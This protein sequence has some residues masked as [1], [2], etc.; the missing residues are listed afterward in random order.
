MFMLRFAAGLSVCA[1][2]APAT[3]LVAIWTP[4]RVLL[5]ADSLVTTNQQAPASGCK[6]AQA[7]STYFALSGLSRDDAAG[8]AA[9]PLATEAARQ[10]TMPEKVAAFVKLARGPLTR[11]VDG[12]RRDSPQDY[13][14]LASG[15]PVLQMIFTQADDSPVLGMAAFNVAPEGG[16]RVHTAVVDGSDARGPRIVY[17]GQQGRIREYLKSHRDWAAGDAARLVNTLI[18]LEIDSG[19]A[20]VGGP[21]D[22]LAITPH[23]AEWL[24][25]KS[26]CGL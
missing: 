7:G 9:A 5:G 6:I 2:L 19:S 15:R 25:R 8:F 18:Q 14:R 23:R 1:S 20:Y 4:D 17:A 24:Q 3:T 21:V 22:I 16:L 12:L 26:G 10:G 11:A 13:L